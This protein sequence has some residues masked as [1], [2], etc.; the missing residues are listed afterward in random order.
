MNQRA[1]EILVFWADAGP[2]RWFAKSVAFDD[3]I[4]ARFG[5]LV[6]KAGQGALDDWLREP[7][8]ALALVIL[9]DQ[10]PRNIYRGTPR[11]FAFDDSARKAADEAIR[12]G[13][14]K[15]LAETH[16]AL[17]KFLYMPFMHSEDWGDQERS[18]ALFRA[19]GDEESLR[20]AE[21]HAD[22]IRRFGRF[23]HRNRILGRPSRDDEIAFLEE[24][25]FKG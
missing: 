15:A 20:H 21:I 25:G 3:E 24:G 6:E 23:P 7:Q 17:S 16:P 11:A 13:F 22:I 4:R 12:R 10:F 8:S 19:S 18:L 2:E 5:E 1:R 14:D 9:L